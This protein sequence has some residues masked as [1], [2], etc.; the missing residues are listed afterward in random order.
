MTL[1]N[2]D[3]VILTIE[4]RQKSLCPVGCYSRHEVYGSDREKFDTW[5][6]IIDEIEGLPFIEVDT[7]RWEGQA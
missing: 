3:A 4:K 1:V 5:Q 2:K 6:E 7:D